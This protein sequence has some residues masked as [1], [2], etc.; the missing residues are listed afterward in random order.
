[1]LT[2]LYTNYVKISPFDIQKND[3]AMKIPYDPNLPIESLFEQIDAAVEFAAAGSNPYT[4][5]QIVSTAYQLVVDTG[6]FLNDYRDWKSKAVAD[7]T[8]PNFQIH[9]TE[10][11]LEMRESQYADLGLRSLLVVV[12]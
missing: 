5:L 9:F 2:H 6:I 3:Q 11:H 12:P 4:T 1:M 10:T 8:W 7:K